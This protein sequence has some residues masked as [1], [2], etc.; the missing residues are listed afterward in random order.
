MLHFNELIVALEKREKKRKDKCTEVPSLKRICINKILNN[1][2]ATTL[3]P[4]VIDAKIH[5]QTYRK[6]VQDTNRHTSRNNSSKSE[7]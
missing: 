5:I 4:S 6:A 3:K 1:N 7:P 2:N